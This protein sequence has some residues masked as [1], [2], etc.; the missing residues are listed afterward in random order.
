ME[1]AYAGT[2]IIR[3]NQLLEQNQILNRLKMQY[4][5]FAHLLS[6]WQDRFRDVFLFSIQIFSDNVGESTI[7][8]HPCPSP[9]GVLICQGW[10]LKVTDRER[11]ICTKLTSD[12]GSNCHQPASECQSRL[13]TAFK[14][15][16]DAT[17]MQM[18][19]PSKMRPRRRTQEAQL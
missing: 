19:M 18:I 3:L 11:S 5:H 4:Y 15:L 13:Q 8:H 9:S 10:E 12:I 6:V 2:Y 17:A 7:C 14:V 1:A 16:L